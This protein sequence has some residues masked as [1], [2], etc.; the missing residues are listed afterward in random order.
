MTYLYIT[1]EIKG[2]FQFEIIIN[3]L[4]HC[5]R[6]VWIPMV[7]VCNHFKLLLQ[8]GGG[9]GST[10]V[11]RIWRLLTSDSDPRAVRAKDDKCFLAMSLSSEI[12]F[13][14]RC[15]WAEGA[16]LSW[17]FRVIWTLDV[18]NGR[19]SLRSNIWQHYHFTVWSYSTLWLPSTRSSI[20]ILFVTTIKMQ[21]IIQILKNGGQLFRKSCLLMSRFIFN[22]TQLQ[23]GKWKNKNPNVI[24]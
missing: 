5:F 3:V 11:V 14:Y 21:K 12:E 7:W 10:L 23:C 4:V 1:M 20:F 24:K 17:H 2:V 15:L 18:I 19:R 9:G 16:W 13:R 8:C 22:V 6:F